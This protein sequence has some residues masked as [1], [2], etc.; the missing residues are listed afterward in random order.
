MTGVHTLELRW[1]RKPMTGARTL[2]EKC[3]VPCPRAE[4]KVKFK[5][6]QNLEC[7]CKNDCSK[8][9][10]FVDLQAHPHFCASPKV[11]NSAHPCQNEAIIRSLSE[12]FSVHSKGKANITQ[13][14]GPDLQLYH[15]V[16]PGGVML[17]CFH[18]K[19]C[20][21]SLLSTVCVYLRNSFKNVTMFLRI[22]SFT[23]NVS[24]QIYTFSREKWNALCS[25]LA[26]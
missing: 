21:K 16:L 17:V 22:K 4:L 8:S 7:S 20:N 3:E 18:L 1:T 26:S 6:A 24:H 9:L 2:E 5:S 25:S 19:F 11:R 15:N 10:N 13:L 12:S 14:C 23:C